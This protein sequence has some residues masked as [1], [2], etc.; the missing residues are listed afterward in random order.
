MIPM[1][2]L[3]VD[4]EVH[5]RF[6]LRK[7]LL[8]FDFKLEI[9]GEVEDGKKA[10]YYYHE[11]NPDLVISDIRMPNCSGM[12]MLKM[13]RSINPRALCVF[14]SAYK[15]FEY[16]QNAIL[17]GANAYLLKPIQDKELYNTIGRLYKEWIKQR[18]EANNIKRVEIEIKKLQSAQ[19]SHEQTQNKNHS[20]ENV[21]GYS[22]LVHN[23]MIYINDHYNEPIS[24]DSLADHV[25]CNKNY[26][27]NIFKKEV[28]KSFVQYLT[29][30][31][32]EKAKML[33]DVGDFKTAEIAQMVGFASDSYFIRVFRRMEGYTPSDYKSAKEILKTVPKDT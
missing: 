11:Y 27:S 3:I 10:Y 15:D 19:D 13:I 2:I 24:L 7:L 22:R 31:R 12:E 18:H 16:A 28:G 23:G 6:L 20:L 25:F 33:L 21:N 26:F 29:E 9:V 4:D 1:K 17:Y 14:I 32:M 30:V 8:S 5:I